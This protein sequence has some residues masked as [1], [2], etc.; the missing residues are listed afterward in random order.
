MGVTH[1]NIDCGGSSTA[2]SGTPF[3]IM[4]HNSVL[5]NSDYC[6]FLLFQYRK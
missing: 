1:M 6:I 2:G 3:D 5:F 4:Q